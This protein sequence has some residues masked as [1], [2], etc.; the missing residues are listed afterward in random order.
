VL[1]AISFAQNPDAGVAFRF[2]VSGLEL[3]LSNRRLSP[4]SFVDMGSNLG[5]ASIHWAKSGLVAL[6]NYFIKPMNCELPNKLYL[7]IILAN[8]ETG[9][10][11]LPQTE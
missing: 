1:V 3:K 2:A 6:I 10:S 11:V 5:P 7:A 9:D 4:K 8:E